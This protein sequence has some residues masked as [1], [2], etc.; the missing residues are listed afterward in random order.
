MATAQNID[1]LVGYSD[2]PVYLDTPTDFTY[3]TQVDETGNT[4]RVQLLKDGTTTTV[5]D[6]SGDAK[7]TDLTVTKELK[8]DLN[9][10]TEG[11]YILQ[12]VRNPS[13]SDDTLDEARVYFSKRS[14]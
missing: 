14:S 6:M 9:L 3:T 5:G 13:G 8:D 4:I 12:V 11:Y 2:D 7:D 10:T 1:T